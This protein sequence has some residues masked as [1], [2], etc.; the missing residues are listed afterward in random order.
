MRI[1]LR[2]PIS[3]LVTVGNAKATTTWSIPKELLT[4][5]SPFLATMITD[6][7]ISL[8]EDNP[9]TFELFIQ[10]LYA[11]EIDTSATNS[12]PYVKAWIL[13]D[14]LKCL[15]FRDHAM[16]Q[17]IHCHKGGEYPEQ[18]L[19]PQNLLLA[20]NGTKAESKLRQW[21]LDQFKF[22]S[23]KGSLSGRSEGWAPVLEEVRDLEQETT[24]ALMRSSGQG[25]RNPYGQGAK[26]LEV[27]K[28]AD[29]RDR[30]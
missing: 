3:I 23:S 19:S 22:N 16:L 20:Y 25:I 5:H 11:G 18:P 2:N 26:Y 24:R 29:F 15:T 1:R 21:A 28:Y 13:G 8:P 7:K 10:W 6:N 30:V 14:K 17:I 12:E 27:L 9:K 4:H